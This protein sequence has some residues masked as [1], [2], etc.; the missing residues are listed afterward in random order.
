MN[1]MKKLVVLFSLM[2]LIGEN[3]LSQVGI[4]T[5]EPHPSAVLQIQRQKGT[6][7]GIG[8]LLPSITNNDRKEVSAADALIAYDKDEKKVVYYDSANRTWKILNIWEQ[9][10]NVS[11]EKSKITTDYGVT[12]NDTLAAKVVQGEYTV[13]KG[14][15]IMWSGDPNNLPHGWVLCDGN[16]GT[17][18][19][20]GRFVVGYNRQSSSTPDIATN[21]QINYGKIGN[22]GGENDVLL[23]ANQ[24]GLP[25]HNH[26]INHNHNINDPG[27]KH[28]INTGR[29]G[30]NGNITKMDTHN[31]AF[32]ETEVSTTGITINPYNGNSGYSVARNAAESHENR[33]PYYVLAFIIKL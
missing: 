7:G 22:T 10:I 33:P 32:K 19:L 2:I 25:A 28:Q 31:A 5:E 21:K 30:G 12:V 23:T 9:S 1:K 24:S 17:P 26:S 6:K 16:N 18:D 14:G 15:I 27:H 13:P 29:N 3:A 20:S 4:N 11:N 8:V